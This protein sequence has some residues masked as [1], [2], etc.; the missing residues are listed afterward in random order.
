MAQ[1]DPQIAYLIMVALS[2]LNFFENC[3]FFQRPDHDALTAKAAVSLLP[4]HFGEKDIGSQ[5]QYRLVCGRRDF[6][7]AIEREL[8][9]LSVEGRQRLKRAELKAKIK[10]ILYASSVFV[11]SI[12]LVISLAQFGPFLM[13]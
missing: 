3:R 6:L 1:R 11:P 10:S 13:F 2:G 12:V 9:P 8:G 5:F 7:P 4:Y